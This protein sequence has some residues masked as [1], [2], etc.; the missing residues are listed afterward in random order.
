[1]AR[2]TIPLLALALSLWTVPASAEPPA[3]TAAGDTVAGKVTN[4]DPAKRRVR[5][6]DND[7]T[8][9]EFEASN[10][11]LGDLKVGDRIEAKRRADKPAK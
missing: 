7:G 11:T 5:V 4:V 9:R 3:G 2:F 1:M 10:E 8:E 6:Q